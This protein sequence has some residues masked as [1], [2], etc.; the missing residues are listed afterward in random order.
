MAPGLGGMAAPVPYCT[1][2]GRT[3]S[4]GV[5]VCSH[6]PGGCVFLS[7]GVTLTQTQFQHFIPPLL[8][9]SDGGSPQDMDCGMEPCVGEEKGQT[10]HKWPEGEAG[11]HLHPQTHSRNWLCGTRKQNQDK[12]LQTLEKAFVLVQTWNIVQD[13]CR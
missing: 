6:N 12:L 9:L 2:G 1:F 5:G 7:S 4:V 13:N 11:V 8:S 10:W 3:G